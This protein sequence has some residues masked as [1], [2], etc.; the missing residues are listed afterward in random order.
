M[1]HE[2]PTSKRWE[3]GPANLPNRHDLRRGIEGVCPSGHL[4]FLNQTL[5]LVTTQAH[6]SRHSGIRVDSCRFVGTPTSRA[7]EG[8]ESPVGHSVVRK[9]PCDS[10]RDS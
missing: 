9:M 4:Q 10:G 6:R 8:L 5:R 1:P 7:R 3:G 2:S